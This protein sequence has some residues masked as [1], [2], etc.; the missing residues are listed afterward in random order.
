MKTYDKNIQLKLKNFL[1][2]NLKKKINLILVFLG[3]KLLIY[4]TLHLFLS[5]FLK[6]RMSF[7][8]RIIFD[9]SK[10]KSKYIFFKIKKNFYCLQMIK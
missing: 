4:K 7:L 3:I 2:M 6:N 8:R 9:I 5:F 10:E 1:Q